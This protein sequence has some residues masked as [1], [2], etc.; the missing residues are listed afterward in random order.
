M[1]VSLT[2]AFRYGREDLDVIGLSFRK[3]IWFKHLQVY[4][5]TSEPKPDNTHV[6]NALLRKTGDDGHPFIF[7]VSHHCTNLDLTGTAHSHSNS[8]FA[9]IAVKSH[10]FCLIASHKSA[11]LC[12]PSTWTRWCWQG[13][14]HFPPRVFLTPSMTSYPISNL[15]SCLCRP[16]VLILKLRPTSPLKQII[17]M[18]RLIKSKDGFINYQHETEKKNRRGFRS[19]IIITLSYWF[20]GTQPV[21][22]SERYSLLQTN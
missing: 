20:V 1:W 12:H 6:Q 15:T 10:V 13:R 5:P 2:C 4:P 3:D 21:W 19:I 9:N 17:Q 8:M 18:N 11:L 7:V 22:L 16:V 14:R